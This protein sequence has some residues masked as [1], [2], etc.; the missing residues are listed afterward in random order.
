[1]YVYIGIAL[2]ARRTPANAGLCFFFDNLTQKMLQASNH[3]GLRL[4]HGRFLVDPDV[5]M[6]DNLQFGHGQTLQNRYRLF[7]PQAARA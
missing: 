1:M 5:T 4:G 7:F 2:R 3:A 6:R